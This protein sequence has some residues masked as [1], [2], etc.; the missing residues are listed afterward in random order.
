LKNLCFLVSIIAKKILFEKLIGILILSANQVIGLAI[1]MRL[2][3]RIIEEGPND[4]ARDIYMQKQ[5][6]YLLS[7]K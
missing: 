7:V 6:N 1:L 3:S 4:I 5:C 2:E